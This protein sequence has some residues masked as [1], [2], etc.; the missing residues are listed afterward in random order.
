MTIFAPAA[1]SIG[2]N[3]NLISNV[4]L[5]T[6]AAPT[7]YIYIYSKTPHNGTPHQRNPLYNGMIFFDGSL[8]NRNLPLTSGNPSNAE[9]GIA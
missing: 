1:H 8:S 5:I 3:I 6:R 4:N 9:Y 2:L 7:E